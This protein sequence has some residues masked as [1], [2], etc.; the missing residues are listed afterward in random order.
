MDDLKKTL[1]LSLLIAKIGV[2]FGQE[3]KIERNGILDS[4]STYMI[5]QNG[6]LIKH[7]DKGQW[8]PGFPTTIRELADGIAYVV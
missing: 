3:F 5:T 1:I 4:R 8:W 7:R 6:L 2:Q